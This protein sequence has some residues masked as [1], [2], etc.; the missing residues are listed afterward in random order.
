MVKFSLITDEGNTYKVNTLNAELNPICHLL[1]LLGTH[2]ILHISRIRI[3][4]ILVAGQSLRIKF[5]PPTSL[6]WRQAADA[7]ILICRG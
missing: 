7:F 2:P 4:G 6:P 3:K 1:A 5:L